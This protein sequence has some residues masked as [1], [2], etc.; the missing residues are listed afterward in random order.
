LEGKPFGRYRLVELLGRGGMGEVWRAHDTRTDRIVAIKV[1]PPQFSDD[2]TFQERFRREAHGAARLDHP[3]VI[4]IHDYGEIDGHLYVDMRLIRGRDL[5]AL[6]ADGALQPG[7][8][9]RIIEQV[10][11]ALHAAH[12]VGLV[13]RDVKPSN[14][15]VDDEDFAYLIDFGIARATDDTRLTGTGNAIGTFQYMAPERMG[16]HPDDARADIYAL[17][18]VLYECLTGQPPFPGTNMGSLVAAHLHTPPPQPSMAKADVPQQLD[19]VIATGMA[20]EPDQRYATTVEL[21]VAAHD[22]VTTSIERPSPKPMTEPIPPETGRPANPIAVHEAATKR[23]PMWDQGGTPSPLP[24]KPLVQRLSRGTKW[25][26]GCAVIAIVTIAVIVISVR[27]NT[28]SHGGALVPSGPATSSRSSSQTTTSSSPSPNASPGLAGTWTGKSPYEDVE[29][30][31]NSPDRL[32]GNVTYHGNGTCTETWT[33]VGRTGS[34]IHV[35]E[36]RSPGSNCGELNWDVTVDGTTLTAQSTW[37][38]SG[39]SNS[40]TLTKT[41]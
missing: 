19:E 24:E 12:K 25:S 14:I 32:D 9:V 41:R 39:G 29:L 7:R 27:S 16:G 10:A 17:A 35:E 23:A 40:L 38:S 6:I 13:H 11:K 5:Q 30:T 36:R 4:P 20:K 2:P 1:L 33:E 21:A 34:T 3:N 18:C 31:I 15:L 37:R 22:A 26:I 8:A 28:S